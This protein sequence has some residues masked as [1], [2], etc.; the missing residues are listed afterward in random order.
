MAVRPELKREPVA[1][2]KV[3]EGVGA[4]VGANGV[5]H[6]WDRPLRSFGVLIPWTPSPF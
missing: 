3:F 1:R 6:P 4:N 5:S 2:S